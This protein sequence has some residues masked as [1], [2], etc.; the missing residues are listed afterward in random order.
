MIEIEVTK[1]EHLLAT[2]H[3]LYSTLLIL[4]A[5]IDA[6]DP[7][8]TGHSERVR[9]LAVGICTAM[10]LDEEFC[11]CVRV[12]SLLHDYGK[13]EIPD[14]ILKKD[15]RLSQEEYEIIMTHSKKTRDILSQINFVGEYKDVAE[16][17]G[18]HH[19]QWDGQG[20]PEALAGEDIHLGAR[21]VAVADY[22]DAVTS[23]RYYRDPMPID[24]AVKLI[25]KQSGKAFDPV[26]VDAFSAISGT[27]RRGLR[28]ISR[29]TG[30]FKQPAN[31]G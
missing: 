15:G 28:R 10:D 22:Y 30:G 4:A 14:A 13:I 7:L 12:A 11:E 20:Y 9:D 25:L 1:A 27:W 16:I 5:S 29:A 21:I 19:E 18:S 3:E 24:V 8:T 31:S 17:A 2:R 26:V 23:K 6:R